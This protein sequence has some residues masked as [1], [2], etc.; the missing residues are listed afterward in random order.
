MTFLYLLDVQLKEAD[1]VSKLVVGDWFPALEVVDIEA[2]IEVEMEVEMEFGIEVSLFVAI[3]VAHR[4]FP[5]FFQCLVLASGT[6]G[7]SVPYNH[8]LNLIMV[9]AISYLLP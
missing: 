2:D 3:L 4:T 1:I 9:L 5:V 8:I 7:A 6:F